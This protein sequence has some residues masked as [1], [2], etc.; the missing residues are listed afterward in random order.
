M[1][2]Q[3][4]YDACTATYVNLVSYN[5]YTTRTANTSEFTEVKEMMG[6]YINDNQFPAPK[7]KH[8]LALLVCHYY[9]L[10]D[11]TAPDGGGS[12]GDDL[13]RGPIVQEVAG[14]MSVT[15]DRYA[16]A[17]AG[18][19]TEAHDLWLMQTRYGKEFLGLRKT[20]KCGPSVT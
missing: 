20:F 16:Q 1:A 15:Y 6:Q 17:T 10:D 19:V 5:K 7:A 11:V 13:T 8:G 12:L 9:A 14:D 4:T 2:T 18:T 3:A